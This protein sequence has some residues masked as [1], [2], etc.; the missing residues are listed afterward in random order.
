M[1]ELGNA[2][3]WGESPFVL[4]GLVSAE[5]SIQ[6]FAAYSSCSCAWMPDVFIAEGG[7]SPI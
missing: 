7:H 1:I 5:C 4:E 3:V 2:W 6:R